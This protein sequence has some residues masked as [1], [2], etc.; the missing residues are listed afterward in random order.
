MT[1]TAY[2]QDDRHSFL[3]LYYLQESVKYRSQCIDSRGF[4]HLYKKEIF[5]FFTSGTSTFLRLAQGFV[6][7]FFKELTRIS[8]ALFFS[9][10]LVFQTFSFFFEGSKIDGQEF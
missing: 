3:R 5:I 2:D 9:I 8:P 1:S 6:I 10:F 7:S 4:F